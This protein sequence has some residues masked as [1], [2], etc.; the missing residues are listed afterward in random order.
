M[1]TFISDVITPEEMTGYVRETQVL[2]GP[3]LEEI[4]P[5]VEKAVKLSRPLSRRAPNPEN[6]RAITQ[7]YKS[8]W[9]TQ[10]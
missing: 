10:G 3:T 9:I 2:Q 4:L 5:E 6:M 8:L 7:G 1:A